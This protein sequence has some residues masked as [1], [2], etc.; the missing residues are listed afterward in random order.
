MRRKQK[1]MSKTRALA[2]ARLL[3][4]ARE[5]MNDGGKHWIKGRLEQASWLGASYC[6]MGGLGK[7]AT[8]GPVYDAVRIA[9]MKQYKKVAPILRDA[10]ILLAEV[11]EGKTVIGKDYD[12]Q[13]DP[14][15][16]EAQDI[17]IAFNDGRHTDWTI[18]SRKFKVAE[19]RARM[20]ANG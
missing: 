9:Q 18:M 12:G 10:T 7:A 17:V 4:N 16:E 15:L 20:I 11:I 13:E 1:T 3:S 14:V 6:A 19:R 2:V 8:N 5:L